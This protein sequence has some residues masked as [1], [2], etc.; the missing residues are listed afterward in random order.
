MA[1]KFEAA[2]H[3]FFDYRWLK[4]KLKK[5]TFQESIIWHDCAPCIA[6]DELSTW[7]FPKTP[8]A[9]RPLML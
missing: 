8:S 2:A 1:S 3:N 6:M 5:K 9:M 4:K 7:N